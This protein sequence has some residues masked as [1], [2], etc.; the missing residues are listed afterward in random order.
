LDLPHLPERP[1]SKMWYIVLYS[2]AGVL[3]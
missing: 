2:S 1:I 3:G